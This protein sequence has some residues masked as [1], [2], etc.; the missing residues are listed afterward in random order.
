MFPYT[1]TMTVNALSSLITN[2]AA[3][4][5]VV[6]IA[7]VTTAVGVVVIGVRGIQRLLGRRR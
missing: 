7:L 5:L 4:P 1:T 6:P 3:I 2:Y